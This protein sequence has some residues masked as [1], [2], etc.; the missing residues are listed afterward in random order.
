[1]PV[2]G[3]RPRMRDEDEGG[4]R[5]GDDSSKRRRGTARFTSERALMHLP[6]AAFIPLRP[7]VT[8]ADLQGMSTSGYAVSD[9]LTALARYAVA[10][11]MPPAV[12]GTLLDKLSDIE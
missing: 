6:L 2:S 8:P 3:G 9:V 4:E 11:A 7:S 12:K 10:M 1:M 5:V